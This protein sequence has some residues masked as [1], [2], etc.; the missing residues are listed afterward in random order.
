[1]PDDA[2]VADA[3]GLLLSKPTISV[4]DAGVTIL[5]LSRNAAYEAAKR[6]DFHTIK[7]GR[8]ILVPTAPLKRQL[9]I[10]TA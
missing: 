7:F 1:M 8:R 2:V 10:E 5:G 4:E 9:G 3:V 6:G